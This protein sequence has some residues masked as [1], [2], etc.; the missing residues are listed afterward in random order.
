MPWCALCSSFLA[1]AAFVVASIAL[2]SLPPNTVVNNIAIVQE[3]KELGS[4]LKED[5]WVKIKRHPSKAKA[6]IKD[7]NQGE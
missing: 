3:L 1:W 4:K 2:Y 7:I 5:T 6:P